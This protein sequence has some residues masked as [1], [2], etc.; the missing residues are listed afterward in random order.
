MHG[1]LLFVNVFMNVCIYEIVNIFIIILFHYVY[2][3][4]QSVIHIQKMKTFAL[5]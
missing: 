1:D 3:Y 5:A 4:Y 2:V